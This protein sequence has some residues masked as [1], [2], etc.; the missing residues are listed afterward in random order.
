MVFIHTISKEMV[1]ITINSDESTYCYATFNI[2]SLL[3]TCGAN[4]FVSL[5]NEFVVNVNVFFQLY[6]NVSNQS[7]GGKKSQFKKSNFN[8]IGA[9]Y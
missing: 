3:F 2:I 1:T 7:I 9:N 6:S 4:R 5:C 8:N